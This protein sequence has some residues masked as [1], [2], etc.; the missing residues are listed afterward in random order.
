MVYISHY[1]FLVPCSNIN[2][3]TILDHQLKKKNAMRSSDDINGKGLAFLRVI[4]SNFKFIFFNWGFSVK[5]FIW[6]SVW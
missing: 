6:L 1:L 5:Q 2:Q 3:L 4:L